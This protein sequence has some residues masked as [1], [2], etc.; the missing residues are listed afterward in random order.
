MKLNNKFLIITFFLV[1]LL[2]IPSK[3]NA[4]IEDTGEK[5]KFAYNDVEYLIPHI[6]D[7]EQ[8]YYFY[9]K[10]SKTSSKL[11][12]YTS[13]NPFFTC[14]ATVNP[15]SNFG[16]G[17]SGKCI[18]YTYDLATDSPSWISY[19]VTT[20]IIG[21]FNIGSGNTYYDKYY[22]NNYGFLYIENGG[23]E[24]DKGGFG[25]QPIYTTLEDFLLVT[26]PTEATLEEVT[27]Q[28]HQ[29][30]KEIT[31]EALEKELVELIPVGVVIL[32]TM[33]LVSLIAFF[34]F[35]KG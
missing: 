30:A 24:F 35:W 9:I 31:A 25:V 5:I 14:T 22:L 21:N 28:A 20:D 7:S 10:P 2:F 6:L 4:V 12:L 13:D 1:A 34:R 23:N 8:P 33:I 3:V 17:Y 27:T 19:E 32:A 16:L 15:T 29:M 18:R 26:P 11:Q